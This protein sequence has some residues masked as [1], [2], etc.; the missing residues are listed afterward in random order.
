M[1]SLIVYSLRNFVGSKPAMQ[2]YDRPGRG[3][4]MQGGRRNG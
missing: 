3:N 1:T 4:G 2:P